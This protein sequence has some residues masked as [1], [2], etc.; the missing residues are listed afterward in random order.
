M[1]QIFS[2]ERKAVLKTLLHS[3][4]NPSY[5]MSQQ[6]DVVR[7]LDKIIYFLRAISIVMLLSNIFDTFAKQY[8]QQH[9]R[10]ILHD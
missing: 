6:E 5:F 1:G 2:L 8:S 4:L 3:L 7:T 9:D 10:W